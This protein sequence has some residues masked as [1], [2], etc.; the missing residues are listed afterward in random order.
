MVSEKK[1]SVM[2]LIIKHKPTFY[3]LVAIILT[4]I[5]MLAGAIFNALGWMTLTY[6]SMGIG[7]FATAAIILWITGKVVA[8]CFSECV[9]IKKDDEE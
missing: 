9:E 5:S 8:S 6:I 4:G 2:K 3:S 1:E 7:L